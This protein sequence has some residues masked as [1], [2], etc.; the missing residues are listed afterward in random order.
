MTTT[1]V[2]HFLGPN[3]HASRPAAAGLPEGTMYV[4]TTHAKIERVVSAAWVD[5]ATLG[6]GLTVSTD[7]IWDT[8]GDLAAASGADAAAKLPVGTDGQILTAD[9][10]QTLGVKWAAAPSGGIPATLLDAKGDLIAASA[11]DTAARLPA[12][13]NGQ[14]LT[15]DSAQTL[16]VKWAAAAS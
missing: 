8:K 9:S 3:T 6:S 14:V 11:N 4:C 2:G 7:T 5:Y 15:A 13:T 10:A 12:G 1:F 16:G